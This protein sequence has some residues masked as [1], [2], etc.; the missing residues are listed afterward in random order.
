MPEIGIAPSRKS[1][2]SRPVVS[3]RQIFLEEIELA[4]SADR[5]GFDTI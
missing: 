3:D 5:L 4:K 1:R 2:A